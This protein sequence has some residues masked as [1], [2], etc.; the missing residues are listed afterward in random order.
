MDLQCKNLK[1][2]LCTWIVEHVD[3]SKYFLS[4]EA[5]VEIALGILDVEYMVGLPC[6]IS[7]HLMVEKHWTSR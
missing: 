3:E 1:R 5:G 4:V 6:L 7:L 2:K